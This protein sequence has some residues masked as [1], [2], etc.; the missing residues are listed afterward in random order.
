MKDLPR[1]L[2]WYLGA[3]YLVTAA[4][5]IGSLTR[6]G[7]VGSMLGHSQ[8]WTWPT[9]SLGAMLLFVLLA[10]V[11]E[12]TTLRV[13]PT[14]SQSLSTTIHIAAILL[15]PAPYPVLITL[16]AVFISQSM[17]VQSPLYK[18][19]F[20]ICHPTIAVAISGFILALVVPP[21]T[22]L[23]AGHIVSALPLLG[24]LLTVYYV[25]DVATLLIVVTLVQGQPLWTVWWQEYRPTLLPELSASVIGILAAVTWQYDPVALVLVVLPVAALRIAFRAIAQAEDRATA[26]RRRGAHLEAVLIAGQ[27]LRL[28]HTRVDFLQPVAQA[29]RT[30]TGAEVV[31]S[32]LRDEDDETLLKRVLVTP[33][34]AVAAGPA[35]LLLSE[36]GGG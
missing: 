8:P 23:H 22:V 9:V 12:R 34:D 35:V 24:L 21:P 28:Q 16:V 6:T 5:V 11:G 4:L 27:S 25:I 18:R 31:T 2:R 17:H 36:A 14:L 10:Y 13:T 1:I 20:N 26:L 15:F 3:L 19:A 29:A 33:E 32:Y 30:L 7:L